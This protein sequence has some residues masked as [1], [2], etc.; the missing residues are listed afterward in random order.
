MIRLRKRLTT[1]LV[2]AGAVAALLTGGV[3]AAPGASA[4]SSDC[5]RSLSESPLCLFDGKNFQGRMLKF[6]AYGCVNLASPYGFDNSAESF[7]NNTHHRAV[8]YYGAN[9][10]GTK[11][12]VAPR[13][14]SSDL[15]PAKNQISSL[16]IFR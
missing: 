5:P 12:D 9:C 14:A 13:S 11:V 3:G 15:G 2:S 4:A 1:A 16:R 10:S 7:I 8:L 6:P